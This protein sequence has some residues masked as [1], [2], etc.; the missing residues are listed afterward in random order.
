[1]VCGYSNTYIISGNVYFYENPFACSETKSW[2]MFENRL[3]KHSNMICNNKNEVIKTNRH[4][5]K[6]VGVA[7]INSQDAVLLKKQ[8]ELL[9]NNEH[10]SDDWEEALFVNNKMII[11]G[12]I[13]DTSC[14]DEINTYEELRNIDDHSSHLNNDT[15]SLIADVFNEEVKSITHIKSLKKGMTN[16]SFLFEINKEKYIMRIPGEGTSQLINR[17]EEYEV[18]QKIKNLR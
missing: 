1:M 12:K 3:S 17:T 11:E 5:L 10:Y 4:G 15:L 13:V 8:L 6:T 16:R 14:V 7:Y 2:Y 9:D 18:Y